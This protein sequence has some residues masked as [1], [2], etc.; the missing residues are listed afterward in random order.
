VHFRPDIKKNAQTE[1]LKAIRRTAISR[2]GSSFKDG[3]V[4]LVLAAGWNVEGEK[5]SSLDRF[6]KAWRRAELL[7]A[8]EL[9]ALDG[10]PASAFQR[11]TRE[12]C[13]WRRGSHG[14]LLKRSIQSVKYKR[15]PPRQVGRKRQQG[16]DRKVLK[17]GKSARKA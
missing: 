2:H 17:S 10:R 15:P 7:A 9:C 4:L 3:G 16:L 14:R 12:L 8:A 1:L 5:L 13:M 11:K 6:G